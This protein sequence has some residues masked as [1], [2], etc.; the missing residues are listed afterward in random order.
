[1]LSQTSDTS[2]ALH[3]YEADLMMILV[4]EIHVVLHQQ[5][6]GTVNTHN[7]QTLSIL[8]TVCAV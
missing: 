6:V 1:M 4:E 7:H 2:W 8:N 5:H 3:Y